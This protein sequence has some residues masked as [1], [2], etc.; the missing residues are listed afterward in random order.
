MKTKTKLRFQDLP[1]D[2]A[3]LCR[4]LLPRP[5]HDTLCRKIKL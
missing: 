3:D 2:S 5:I 4:V 1:K